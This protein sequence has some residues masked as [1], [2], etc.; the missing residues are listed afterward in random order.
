M[1]RGSVRAEVEDEGSAVG[2]VP[3]VDTEEEREAEHGRGL[4]IVDVLA[5]KHGVERP[6]LVWFELSWGESTLR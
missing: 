2:D 3:H 5:D 1:E 6:N 4:A